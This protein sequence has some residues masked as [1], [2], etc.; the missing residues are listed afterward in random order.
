M[1]TLLFLLAGFI[2]A[3]GAILFGAAKDGQQQSLGGVVA[4]IA[5]LVAALGALARVAGH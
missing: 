4:M 3:G 5:L 2:F 1:A